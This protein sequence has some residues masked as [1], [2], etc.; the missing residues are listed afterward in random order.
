MTPRVATI[1]LT[2]TSDKERNLN[3]AF[4]ALDNA[5]ARGADWVLLPEI[6]TYHGPYERLWE[7]AEQDQGPL[8]HRLAEWALSNKV[9]LIAGSFA[10]RPESEAITDRVYNRMYV[11]NRQGLE[12]ARYT[13]TH[14]FNL[15]DDSGN[16][17]YCESEGYIPGKEAVTLDI[18]GFHVGLTICYDLRFPGLYQRLAKDQ[19]IDVLINAAAFTLATGKAHWETL[20]KAR[21][22]EYQAYSVA[23][24]QVGEHSPGKQS[25]GHSMIID[26]WGEILASTGDQAGIAIAQ[27]SIQRLKE[28]RAMLPAISNRRPELY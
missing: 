11:F 2:A 8:Y 25:Y 17:L 27:L 23:A 21:S 6:F 15:Y 16:P 7:M 5:A 14:L 12:I 3:Q 20:L 4:E 19:P 18:D 13:K 26:P 9:V 22:I 10:V 24:N 1:S 28:V